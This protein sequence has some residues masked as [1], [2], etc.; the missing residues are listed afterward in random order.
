ME[1]LLSSPREHSALPQQL[2]RAA[3]LAIG[4]IALYKVYLRAYD[5]IW[6]VYA[7]RRQLEKQGI[8]C[9]P[10]RH[11][12]HC[13]GYKQPLDTSVQAFRLNGAR[14]FQSLRAGN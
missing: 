14:H 6:R 1:E 7:T 10:F 3:L 13:I 8:P 11:E 9:A 5:S 12:K 2:L 4:V